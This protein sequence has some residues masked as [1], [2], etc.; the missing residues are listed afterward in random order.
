MPMF[1]IC[2]D[3]QTRCANYRPEKTAIKVTRN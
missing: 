2:D 3:I 1:E